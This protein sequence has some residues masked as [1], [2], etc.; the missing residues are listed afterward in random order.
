MV[1]EVSTK[2]QHPQ[3]GTAWG[4]NWW[5]SIF[6]VLQLPFQGCWNC[7]NR[8]EQLTELRIVQIHQVGRFGTAWGPSRAP[9]TFWESCG[10]LKPPCHYPFRANFSSS[11]IRAG[12]S[13][14]GNQKHLWSAN[15]TWPT[16]KCPFILKL[17]SPIFRSPTP[18][19]TR[20]H[21][22]R[23][24]HLIALKS[25]DVLCIWVTDFANSATKTN[26]T[27]LALQSSR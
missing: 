27:S 21:V 11:G 5:A 14:P 7:W 20:C 3:V 22:Q 19:Q 9:C 12:I 10:P 16:P 1:F 17:K 4:Q 13:Q 15:Q 2:L 6:Q 25:I 8:P 24:Y 18:C 26:W 23:G